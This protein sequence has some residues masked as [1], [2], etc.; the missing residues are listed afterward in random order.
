MDFAGY[1]PVE[2]FIN[3]W[4]YGGTLAFGY[5]FPF[6][7]F[8]GGLIE[9]SVSPDLSAQ[10][11]QQQDISFSSPV[12]GQNV[13]LRKQQIRNVSFELTMGFRFLHKVVYLDN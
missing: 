3:K 9:F 5:E 8:V 11:N 4:N 12:S 2:T 10:Y 6:S 7:E 13:T 1:L